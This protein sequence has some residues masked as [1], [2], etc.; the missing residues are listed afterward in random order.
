MVPRAETFCMT[1][2]RALGFML[3]IPRLCPVVLAQGIEGSVVYAVST[4]LFV[5]QNPGDY[6]SIT[7]TVATASEETGLLHRLQSEAVIER[8]TRLGLPFVMEADTPTTSAAADE[9][10]V[11]SLTFQ[12]SQLSALRY[13][14]GGGSGDRSMPLDIGT[15][16]DWDAETES[17]T[18]SNIKLEM[19]GDHLWVVRDLREDSDEEWNVGIQLKKT[20]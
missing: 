14:R 2:W 3:L 19:L 6:A 17:Y 15:Q 20:W 11:A 1:A 18:L 5:D 13:W 8:V 7:D 12:A 9:P 16:M 10:M 4:N